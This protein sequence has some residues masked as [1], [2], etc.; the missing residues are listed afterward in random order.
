MINLLPA[1]LICGPSHVDR[2]ALFYS[3][4]RALR[5]RQI[6][7]YALHACYS[8]KSTWPQ[9]PGQGFSR[10]LRT[11]D[12][13]NDEL[14]RHFC[15]DLSQRLVPLL[16]DFDIYD[17][18]IR[19]GVLQ[20]CSHTI[21]LHYEHDQESNTSWLQLSERYG[22]L[23]L[24]HVYSSLTTTHSTI[25]T[26][27]PVITGTFAQLEDGSFAKNSLFDCLVERIAELFTAY[28]SEDL[29]RMHVR[30][31]PTA[32]ALRLPT[33]LHAIAPGTVEWEPRMLNTLFEYIPSDTPL[34]AYGP[35][36]QW[37]YGALAAY[38]ANHEFYH[39]DPG[40]HSN[41]GHSGWVA[42]PPLLLS[43]TTKS[44]DYAT[45]TEG[46][47]SGI[48]TVNIIH[49]PLYYLQATSLPFPPVPS[50]Q[51]LILA[52]NIPTWLLTAL[53]RLY[54]RVDVA[55][56]A[57]H[58]TQHNVAVVVFSQTMKHSIGDIISTF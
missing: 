7:H 44:E 33:L 57:C 42:T 24:A 23:P 11:H 47:E 34:S 28:S 21:L 38:T 17:P 27:E 41:E 31:A 20:Q 26:Q 15:Q 16:I 40:L 51:G 1:V 43:P 14:W 37:L 32:L 25:T 3:L 29:V 48:L 13:W 5:N 39:F 45:Y 18:A 6:S 49:E 58:Q 35:G 12:T 55:W 9:E 52:G 56:I 8:C 22:L 30:Q 2:S 46:K 53:V 54:I 19:A 10:L 36:P 4:T 50:W